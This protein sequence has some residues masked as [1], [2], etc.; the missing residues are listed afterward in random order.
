MVPDDA[1]SL[2]R[3]IKEADGAL[4]RSKHRGRNCVTRAG[5]PLSDAVKSAA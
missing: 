4:Y 1:P 2:E 5:A 3:L